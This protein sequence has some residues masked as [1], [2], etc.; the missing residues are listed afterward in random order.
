M[1]QYGLL[2]RSSCPQRQHPA[3]GPARW[4]AHRFGL[5]FESYLPLLAR[6]CDTW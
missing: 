4:F 6:C 1:R 3:G 5:S 2:R